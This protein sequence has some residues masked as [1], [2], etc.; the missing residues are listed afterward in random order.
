MLYDGVSVRLDARF[1]SGSGKRTLRH[2]RSDGTRRR[3]AAEL[4]PIANSGRL[5]ELPKTQAMHKSLKRYEHLS[6]YC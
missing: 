1:T 2:F 5:L 4:G 6:F 3:D